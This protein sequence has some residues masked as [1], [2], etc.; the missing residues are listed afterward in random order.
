MIRETQ[1]DDVSRLRLR[2]ERPSLAGEDV[3]LTPPAN[4]LRA[5]LPVVQ[6][7]SCY[8]KTQTSS[9]YACKAYAI[10][11][12][13][14]SSL[15][16]LLTLYLLLLRSTSRCSVSC[17]LRSMSHASSVAVPCTESSPSLSPSLPLS[18]SLDSP[19]ASHVSSGQSCFRRPQSRDNEGSSL[20]TFTFYK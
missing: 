1:S 13:L 15:I 10:A 11:P 14:L 12:L 6:S 5:K 9:R 8:Q 2:E 16:L 17:P 18:L 19:S 20:K 7:K 4:L 3:T